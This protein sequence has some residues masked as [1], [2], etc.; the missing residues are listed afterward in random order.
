M[1]IVLIKPLYGFGV[2]LRRNNAHR[3]YQVIFSSGV[4]L[5][6]LLNQHTKFT[7]I[8]GLQTT[9]EVKNELI[10]VNLSNCYSSPAIVIKF[11]LSFYTYMF[12]Q[13]G[14]V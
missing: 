1:L 14:F 5:K 2:F 11:K 9:I 12:T 3:I 13:Q 10:E 7:F 6:I 8:I 4:G